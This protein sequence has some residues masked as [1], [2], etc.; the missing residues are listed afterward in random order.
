MITDPLWKSVLL[1]LAPNCWVAL[2]WTP[3]SG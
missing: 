1:M 2:S 3:P